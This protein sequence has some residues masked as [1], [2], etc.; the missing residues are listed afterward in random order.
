MLECNL[1]Q[2]KIIACA[3]NDDN[4]HSISNHGGANSWEPSQLETHL[5]SE[6]EEVGGTI[7]IWKSSEK[8]N[9]NLP[10]LN[11]A[12]LCSKKKKEKKESKQKVKLKMEDNLVRVFQSSRM[13]RFFR[14]CVLAWS[15]EAF[16]GGGGAG[17]SL[18][19]FSFHVE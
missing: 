3:D 10:G 18:F 11:L 19:Y 15:R 12:S 2:R 13:V 5:Q 6:Q 1:L 17:R 14:N 7:E 16:V 8:D 9:Q 4:N